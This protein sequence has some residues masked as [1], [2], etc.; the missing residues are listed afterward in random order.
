MCVKEVKGGE[1]G[2]QER[3]EWDLIEVQL[4]NNKILNSFFLII[5]CGFF[6]LQK[7]NLNV[8]KETIINISF[9][10]LFFISRSFSGI[11][12]LIFI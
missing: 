7:C 2:G 10:I 6:F 9:I 5:Y 4:L 1:G 12:I 3:E 11:G 8:Y